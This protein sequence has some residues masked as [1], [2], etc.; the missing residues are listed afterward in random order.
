M[1]RAVTSLSVA[2][3]CGAG[4]FC[5]TAAAH[6][7]PARVSPAQLFT[8]TTSTTVP[9]TVRNTTTLPPTTPPP[10]SAPPTTRR[11]STTTSTTPRRTVPATTAPPE[12]TT[13][14][15]PLGNNLPPPPST[16]PL[17][18]K[19]QSAHVSPLFP[20]LSGIGF[21]VALLIAGTQAVLTRPGRRSTWRL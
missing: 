6:S 13:T 2:A 19:Q 5:S 9:T 11:P 12:T 21:L 10:T 14:V 18:T 7:A 17:A 8:T 16:L 3:A 15:A 20:V 1:R 4:L